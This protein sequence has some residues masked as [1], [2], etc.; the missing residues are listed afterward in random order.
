MVNGLV[1]RMSSQTSVGVDRGHSRITG[2]TVEYTCISSAVQVLSAYFCCTLSYI[3]VVYAAKPLYTWLCNPYVWR[4]LLCD[5][6]RRFDK[7]SETTDIWYVFKKWI[8]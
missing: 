4:N 5:V 3:M 8:Y 2:D 6:K 1:R 7:H